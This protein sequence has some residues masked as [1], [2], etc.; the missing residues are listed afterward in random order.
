VPFVGLSL[1][2]ASDA[3][4]IDSQRPQLLHPLLVG[5][6][7]SQDDVD[8]VE[9]ADMAERHSPELRG[10]GHDDD[11]L[12][13]SGGGA[14][15]RRLGEK[16]GSNARLGVDA[17]R[18][19]HARVES[20]LSNRRFSESPRQRKLS[21]TDLPTREEE[22][23]ARALV[24]LEDWPEGERHDRQPPAADCSCHLH[25]SGTTVENDGL[26]VGQEAGRG[27]AYRRLGVAKLEGPDAVWGLLG[28][29]E[30]TR[31]PAVHSSEPPA[32]LERLEITPHGH[33]R[34]IQ[35][36]S[37]LPDQ[38]RTALAERLQDHLVAEV[39]IHS[40]Q[41]SIFGVRS[42]IGTGRPP[43]ETV[44]FDVGGVLLDWNPRHLYRKLFAIQTEME[45]FLGEVC[46]PAWHAPHD[47]GVST[48]ASCAE[49]ASRHPELSELIWAWSSRS[50]EMIRGVDAE[51]V[52]VLSAVRATGLPCYALTNM[53][54]E[55]YPL[56]LERFPFLGWFDGTVVSGR[57]GVAKP[58]P[59]I[60][61]RLLDRFGLTPNTTLM[62]DDA[63]ENLETAN[64]LGIQT[65]LFRSA[66]QLRTEL[67]AV[68][69]LA[70]TPT[71]P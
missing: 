43:V 39:H 8:L 35:G 50:E 11:S 58:E 36:L 5:S 67:E 47:L 26:P 9:I 4:D 57:E 10:I 52:G 27:A 29:E 13:G 54:A 65:A 18:A 33:F 21:R 63:K 46:S 3:A 17:A 56:R 24:Q 70:R 69:V 61:R 16:V 7:I 68:G 15:D 62:I 2:S 49:L 53:E 66:R 64:R 71:A 30:D 23:D 34:A 44:V 32:A 45:W 19:H 1:D 12:R 48:A 6:G 20:E 51:S 14:L 55:T 28:A 41:I 37:Q 40:V 60:F 38:H 42:H 22:F 31:R 59:A 25:S